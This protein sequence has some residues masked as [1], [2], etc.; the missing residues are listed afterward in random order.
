MAKKKLMQD[1]TGQIFPITTADAVY[2][3]DGSK[4]IKKYVDDEL[5]NL[6]DL[7]GSGTGG[8]GG[9]DTSSEHTHDYLPLTGGTISG[10]LYVEGSLDVGENLTVQHGHTALN[11][12]EA[13]GDVTFDSD[14]SVCYGTT[15]VDTLVVNAV[16]NFNDDISVKS[17]QSIYVGGNEVLNTSN[18]SNHALP[19]VG[20]TM[21]GTLAINKNS[22]TGYFD[23][24][25]NSVYMYNETAGKSVD[26]NNDGTL[27]F[28]GNTVL[29]AGNYNSYALP[30]TGGT[31]TG[32]VYAENN[33]VIDGDLTAYYGTTT[34]DELNVYNV[35]TFGDDVCIGDGHTIYIGQ[36]EVYHTGNKP[37]ASEIGAFPTTGGTINGHLYTEGDLEVGGDLIAQYGHTVVN[38]LE[39]TGVVDFHSNLNTSADINCTATITANKYNFPTNVNDTDD[40]AYITVVHTDKRTAMEFYVGNNCQIE[41]ADDSQN[42]DYQATN[43]DRFI[44]RLPDISEEGYPE[45][46]NDDSHTMQLYNWWMIGGWPCL[47][48]S[49]VYVDSLYSDTVYAECED[50]HSTIRKLRPPTDNTSDSYLG[51][52]SYRFYDVYCT[53]GAFNGSDSKLK[54]DIKSIS[55]R[56]FNGG[57][58]LLSDEEVESSV[59]SYDLY[60]YIKNASLYSYKYKT[61]NETSDVDYYVGILADNV[62]DNV[63]NVIG[64]YSKT[65]EEYQQEIEE[66]PAIIERYNELLEAGVYNSEKPGVMDREFGMSLAEIRDRAL[67]EPEEPVRLINA[68][69]Q[70]SML[71]EVLSIAINK[72]EVLEARIEELENN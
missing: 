9:S 58:E 24:G 41:G 18:Y 50:Y 32:D 3:D 27:S 25:T 22:N 29:H 53:R 67:N 65:E 56:D 5:N 57:I 20:G 30:L 48:V 64:T 61:A 37:T 36:G 12:L 11:T 23:V 1:S 44:W 7:I 15:T 46:F 33:V 38:T 13:V 52:S 28:G 40:Y 6:M 68:P 17:G 70:V 72:I 31:I 14:L 4:T 26:V 42:S 2:L 21:T 60:D 63:F 16:G 43:D 39:A 51:E 35:A 45:L 54:E 47:R 49:E 19:K 69:A 62:P 10:E 71:Q 66:R 8:T 34:L 55:R 59:S